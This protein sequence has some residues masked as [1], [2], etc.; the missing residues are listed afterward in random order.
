VV[1]SVVVSSMVVSR[2]FQCALVAGR[3]FLQCFS[4]FLLLMAL[5]LPPLVFSAILE[6]I[7]D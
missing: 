4:V 7:Q 5:A 6:V 2:F 1:F 3:F